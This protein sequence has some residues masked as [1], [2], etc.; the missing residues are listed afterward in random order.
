VD[1]PEPDKPITTKISPA[2]TV[3]LVSWTPIGQPGFLQD[4]VLGFSGLEQLESTLGL[5]PEDFVQILDDK[6]V[7]L[8]ICH[9]CFLWNCVSSTAQN[10]RDEYGWLMS[11]SATRSTPLLSVT[12]ACGC[13][14]AG[15][16]RGTR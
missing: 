15:S 13:K 4:L 3:K 6:L 8:V 10:S 9:D 1:L 11:A 2:L 7:L 16:G 14:R 5:R 12:N